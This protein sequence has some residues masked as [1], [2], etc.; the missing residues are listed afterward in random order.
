VSEEGGVQGVGTKNRR[1]C[2][3]G[4]VVVSPVDVLSTNLLSDRLLLKWY[5][6][7]A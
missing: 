4:I 2:S 5:S 7:V 3:M 6:T 1:S